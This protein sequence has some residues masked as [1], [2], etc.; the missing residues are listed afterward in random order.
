MNIVFVTGLYVPRYSAVG[1]CV[2]NLAAEMARRHDVTV[3]S[4]K[5]GDSPLSGFYGDGGERLEYTASRIDGI[6][7]IAQ[8]KMLANEHKSLW[9]LVD[10]ALSAF[11]YGSRMMSR[12]AY[13][14]SRSRAY[15]KALEGLEPKPDLLIPCAGMFENV[16]AC[17]WYKR[18]HPEVTLTPILFDQFAYATSLYKT[19]IEKR[20]HRSWNLK[21]EDEVLAS[22]DAIFTVT[23]DAHIKNAHPRWLSKVHHIEHP[24]LVPPKLYEESGV[25]TKKHGAVFA[26]SLD[27]TVR[28]AYF[29]IEVFRQLHAISPEAPRLE[30]YALGSGAVL[31]EAAQAETP[32][33]V[34]AHRPLLA[35]E[36]V[37]VL[38]NSEILVS[39]GNKNSF[40]KPSKH[41]EYM[42]LGKPIVHFSTIDDDPTVEDFINYPLALVLRE[43][44]GYAACAKELNRFLLEVRGREISFTEVEKIFPEG[45]P[46]YIASEIAQIAGGGCM[47]FSGTLNPNVDPSYLLSMLDDPICNAI[48]VHFYAAKTPMREKV[49]RSGIVGVECYDWVLPS[50]L[51][52]LQLSAD[53]LIS[54]A[55]CEGKQI[56]SKIYEYM[57]LG[58]PVMHL[59]TC[60]NDVNL[61]YL[62]NY[63]FALCLKCDAKELLHNRWRMILWLA[64]V[65]GRRVSFEKAVKNLKELTPYYVTNQIMEVLNAER[66]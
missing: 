4:I 20:I 26:G 19:N 52:K 2:K 66:S 15:L 29:A 5:Q 65:K 21:V 62:V 51:V 47:I 14:H 57:S 35:D 64:W 3:L 34:V 28:D 55:E 9:H 10:R 59:Y 12:A 61:K 25:D 44:S 6:K 7:S 33:V 23:W 58:K 41:I 16:M 11:L 31:P 37:S 18:N 13:H 46:A 22:S 39:I 8:A 40:Q 48:H 38:R 49:E 54:I 32:S 53:A 50:K 45:S 30:F 56:S 42:A 63:P 17:V 60:D 36:M 27:P 1:K 43:S 24:M